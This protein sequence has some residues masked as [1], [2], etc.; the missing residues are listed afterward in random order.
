MISDDWL[1]K[2]MRVLWMENDYLRIGILVGRGSDIF[3]FRYKPLDLNFML[4]LEKEIHNPVE[5]MSQIRDTSNQMEDYYYGGW[6]E[7]LPNS[8]AGIYRNAMLGQ[9]G[10]I[11]MIPWKHSIIENSAEKV[12]VKLWTRPLRIP[13][14][15]EK[16]LTLEANNPT[17]Y[18]Q[19]TIKNEGGTDLDIMWGHHIAFGLPFLR[20]GGFIET[21]AKKI[22]AEKSMPDHRIYAPEIESNWPEIMGM[23]QIPLNASIIPPESSEPYSELAYLYD[24]EEKANYTIFNHRRDLGF[25]LHW[26][27][28]IF[29]YLWHWQERYATQDAP[30][31][32]KAY[33]IALEPWT[34][35][36]PV[37]PA[38]S[39]N[40]GEYLKI[41]S[42][43]SINSSMEASVIDHQSNK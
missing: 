42:G 35:K 30:W 26:N 15:I 31:W 6:Q 12:S 8:A 5:M 3:E 14:L 19:E 13:I 25:S 38:S 1:Y 16:T 43:S 20:Q 9:H 24:F 18:I 28:S 23:N 36:H 4:K 41:Q 11:W 29:R 27:A 2:N 17:L 34:T 22:I 39:I 7:V 40:K 33:A 32:G 10:E 21:N 37:D